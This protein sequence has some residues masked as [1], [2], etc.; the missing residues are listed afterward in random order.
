MRCIQQALMRTLSDKTLS[1]FRKRYYD[2]EIL[3]NKGLY[4]DCAKDLRSSIE[5]LME[6][7]GRVRRM[8]S[9]MT[10]SKICKFSQMELLY[11]CIS[12][13][14]KNVKKTNS[15]ALPDR[16]KHYT[17]P[18]SFNR[19]IY[20]QY[21]TDVGERMKQTLTDA[22]QLL[23]LCRSEYNDS[24]EYELSVRCLSEQTIVDNKNWKLRTKEDCDMQST[25]LP[26]PSN[27]ETTFRSK[28]LKEH[29]AYAANMEKSVGT[30]ESVV[31]EY[32]YGQNIHSDSEFIREHLEQ[33]DVQKERTGIIT[34]GTYS[35]RQIKM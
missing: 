24:T 7:S 4:H 26:T 5:K 27:P 34:D 12:K 35:L 6:V 3:Y 25:M 18:D 30:N 17:D 1:R 14:V 13:L 16:L 19:A 21:S 29:R 9:M 10:A 15:S 11:T 23:I 2:H 8:D 28:A 32:Q 22:N 31:T 20:H 33:M